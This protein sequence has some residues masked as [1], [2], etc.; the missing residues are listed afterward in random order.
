[1]RVFYRRKAYILIETEFCAWKRGTWGNK[2][3]NVF[4][5][6]RCCRLESWKAGNPCCNMLKQLINWFPAY[7]GKSSVAVRT[8]WNILQYLC[9]LPASCHSQQ[10]PTWARRSWPELA[11]MPAEMG[12]NAGGLGGALFLWPQP[13]SQSF[14]QLE[15]STASIPQTEAGIKMFLR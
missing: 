3:S 1:M 7:S 14:L 2:T 5:T 10:S 9:L 11:S 6:H 15:T 12:G 4:S 13:K 8:R